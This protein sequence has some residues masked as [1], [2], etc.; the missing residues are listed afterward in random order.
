MR[1]MRKF[2]GK[3]IRNRLAVTFIGMMVLFLLVILLINTFFLERVYTVSREKCILQTY[4]ALND[5]DSYDT[6]N[7]R[8]FG[9]YL[10]PRFFD[11][12]FSL[13]ISHCHISRQH[14]QYPLP[15]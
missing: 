11:E 13:S 9:D 8:T 12:T 3:S 2:M 15:A 7:T 4:N 10:L 1:V 5:A 14:Y 6:L